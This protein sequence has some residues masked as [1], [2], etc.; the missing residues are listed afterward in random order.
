M[1]KGN[2]LKAASMPNSCENPFNFVVSNGDF[3]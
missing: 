2:L 3:L 1:H